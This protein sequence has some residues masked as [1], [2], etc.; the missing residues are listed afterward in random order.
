MSVSN[1]YH[2]LKDELA[3]QISLSFLTYRAVVFHQIQ[4]ILEAFKV[5]FAEIAIEA[6]ILM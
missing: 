4:H 6:T 1:I 2:D 3:S 5:V